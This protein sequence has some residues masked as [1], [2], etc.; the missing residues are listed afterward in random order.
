MP[1]TNASPSEDQTV[2]MVARNV[3]IRA[4]VSSTQAGAKGGEECAL[5][6]SGNRFIGAAMWNARMK[7]VARKTLSSLK[8]EA[9]ERVRAEYEAAAGLS[10]LG[11][12]RLNEI[13]KPADPLPSLA[14]FQ[15]IWLARAG[16]VSSF[17]VNLGL[18]D[19]DDAIRIIHEFVDAHPEFAQTEPPPGL[20]DA[21]HTTG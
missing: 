7:R 5:G 2:P 18:I 8:L 12:D 21:E 11:L 6:Q 4:A 10:K 17:A 14:H 1:G 9:L 19:P 20:E 13:R 15:E 16:A 3:S